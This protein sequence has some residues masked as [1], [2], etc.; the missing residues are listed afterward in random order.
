[1]V[2]F[3]YG[4][5]TYYIVMGHVSWVGYHCID[6]DYSDGVRELWHWHMGIILALQ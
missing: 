1:M 5:D 6:F 3:I 4:L 2:S